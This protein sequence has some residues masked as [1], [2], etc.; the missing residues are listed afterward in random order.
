MGFRAEDGKLTGIVRPFRITRDGALSRGWA[1]VS[2]LLGRD[3]GREKLAAA[4][5]PEGAVSEC[6]SRPLSRT[7]IASDMRAQVRKGL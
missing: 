2:G 6:S 7:G 4:S 1:G 3:A 5:A